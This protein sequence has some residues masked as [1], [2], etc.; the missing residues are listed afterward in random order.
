MTRQQDIYMTEGIRR[1]NYSEIVIDEGK[2]RVF[3]GYSIVRTI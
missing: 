3:V 2:A 1:K